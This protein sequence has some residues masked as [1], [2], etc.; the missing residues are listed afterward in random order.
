MKHRVATRFLQDGTT[1][2]SQMEAYAAGRE[3][4]THYPELLLAL[5]EYALA[6]LVEKLLE[7]EHRSVKCVFD[8][9][10]RNSSLAFVC[11]HLRKKMSLQMLSNSNFVDWLMSKRR[12]FDSS[13]L[14]QHFIP[15]RC[16][17]E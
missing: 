14:L 2:R 13:V 1:L 7:G 11:A 10:G 17:V 12:G 3:P 6:L 9:I 8:K 16:R 4:L 15:F 5:Q